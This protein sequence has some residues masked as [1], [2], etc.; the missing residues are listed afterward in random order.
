M[1][2]SAIMSS[3]GTYIYDLH[4]H[5]NV[6]DGILSPEMLVSRAKLHGVDVLALTDHDTVAGISIATQAAASCGIQLIPGIEFSSQWCGRNIHVVGL[7]IDPEDPS[8]VEAVMSQR[9]VRLRRA[10][11]IAERL[12]RQGIQGSLAGAERMAGGAV[13][14]RPHFARYLVEQ[15]VVSSV[16]T[17]FKRYLGTGK[18]GDVKVEW[19]DFEQVIAWIRQAGGI[20]VLAHPHKYKLTRTKLIRMATAFVSLGGQAMEV[21]CGSQ[22]L[23]IAE[24]LSRIA[25]ALGLC[26]SCGSDFHAPGQKWQELGAFGKLPPSVRPVW[27]LWENSN[28]F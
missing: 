9:E 19:P 27:E 10:E 15:G 5:S 22:A 12:S 6:S 7:N 11:A 8:L 20:A 14:G 26:A 18:A 13:I 23:A 4:T 21:Q 25:T 17:A 28:E 2:V 3:S 1:P 24:D 16:E